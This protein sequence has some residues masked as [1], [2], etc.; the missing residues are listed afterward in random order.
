MVGCGYRDICVRIFGYAGVWID[1]WAWVCG[2][3]L[4]VMGLL[5]EW[6]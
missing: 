3:S 2:G 1:G 6:C 4:F 5:C